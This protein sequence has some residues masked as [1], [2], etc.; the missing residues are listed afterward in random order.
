LGVQLRKRRNGQLNMELLMSILT[1]ILAQM[2]RLR[3][4]K[5]KRKKKKRRTILKI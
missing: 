3:N 5:K 1:V 2:L 4:A